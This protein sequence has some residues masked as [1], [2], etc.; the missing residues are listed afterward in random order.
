MSIANLLRRTLGS[1]H[2]AKHHMTAIVVAGG[3]GARVGADRP[4]QWLDLCGIPVVIHTLCALQNAT[5][6][7]EI[8]VVG[9]NED[10]QAYHDYK[11]IH[12]L[13]KLANVVV[14]G[15]T[16]QASVL[17]GLNAVSAE[18]DFVCIH[19]GARPL[20]TPEQIDRVA[21]AAFTYRAATAAT[22]ATDTIKLVNKKGK[23]AETIDR[24]KVWQAQTPQIFQIELYHAAVAMAKKDN[25]TATDDCMLAEHAGFAIQPVDLGHENFKITVPSDI[26]LADAIL[27][28]RQ[29]QT[30]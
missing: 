9:R 3:V 27:R 16:R 10:L 29:T 8:V 4:K 22:P 13:T 5:S 17:A 21:V 19:D 12:N 26:V 1:A 7:R 15:D 11:K 14:G 24:T 28:L 20:I 2:P 25:F 23:I 6:V 18:T 30:S